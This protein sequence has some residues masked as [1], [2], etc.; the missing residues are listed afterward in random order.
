MDECTWRGSGGNGGAGDLVGYTFGVS[1]AQLEKSFDAPGGGINRH[2]G[3]SLRG[4]LMEF[5][6][7]NCNG[8]TAGNR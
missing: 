5:S 4:R 6:A 2:A 7:A 1:S 8:Y 3:Q